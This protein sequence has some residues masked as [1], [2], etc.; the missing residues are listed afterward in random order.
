MIITDNIISLRNL[1]INDTDQI[2]RWENDINNW[3]VSNTSEVFS[4]EDIFDFISKSSNNIFV[5]L[6]LRLMIEYNG[7][8]IGSID[9]FEFEVQHK[10]AGIG[11]LIDKEYRN[12]SFATSAIKLTIDYCKNVLFIHQLYCNI[13]TDNTISIKLFKKV[14]FESLCIKKDWF[15]YKSKWQDVNFLQYIIS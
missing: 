8:T 4:R 7:I 2:L 15:L 10:K 1:N 6:Q 13:H 3:K 9:L 12:K 5:D 14:G 11:I